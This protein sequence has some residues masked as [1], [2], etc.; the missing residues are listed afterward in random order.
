MKTE[1]E[2]ITETIEHYNLGNRAAQ[3][4]GE[5]VML[6]SRGNKCAVGRCAIEPMLNDS[7]TDLLDMSCDDRDVELKP[8]YRG[9]SQSFWK[10]LQ[11]LHDD[12]D[13]WTADG[14][15][16]IGISRV[17]HFQKINHEHTNTNTI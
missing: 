15:S 11:C 16:N 8:E 13:N 17:I 4:N 14:L 3:P 2:I 7:G 9:H 6:D 12:M 1:Q 5:C 10:K